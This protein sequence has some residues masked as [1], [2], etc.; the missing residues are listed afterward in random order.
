MSKI[1]R[2]SPQ[3][4]RPLFAEALSLLLVGAVVVGAALSESGP[5]SPQEGD[6]FRA[7]TPESA[8]NGGRQPASLLRKTQK[9]QGPLRVQLLSNLSGP[10]QVGDVFEITAEVTSHSPLSQALLL[11]HLPPGLELVSG[12]LQGELRDLK[13]HHPQSLSLQV[14]QLAE[15][16]LQVHVS[17][18]G[19]QDGVQFASAGQFN[20]QHFQELREIE[21]QIQRKTAEH[22]ES[23]GLRQRLFH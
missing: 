11:W 22:L 17:V 23:Q 8:E 1:S 19:Q 7:L 14:R 21:V 4:R 13:A 5:S 3:G 12:S 9:L 6:R 15:E 18:Q 20:T 10:A 16:N 2:K